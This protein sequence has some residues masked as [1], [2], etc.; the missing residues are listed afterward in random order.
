M[1]SI[2][3]ELK[4]QI[5]E[6]LRIDFGKDTNNL[7]HCQLSFHLFVYI[8]QLKKELEILKNDGSVKL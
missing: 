1:K 2:P 4:I 6:E 5:L 7:I 8:R 3:I